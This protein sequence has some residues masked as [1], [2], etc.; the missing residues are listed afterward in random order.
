MQTP[1]P[2]NVAAADTQ[3]NS[4]TH[5]TTGAKKLEHFLSLILERRAN[6]GL[7]IRHSHTSK[8]HLEVDE[9]LCGEARVCIQ[10]QFAPCNRHPAQKQNLHTTPELNN[11]SAM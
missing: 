11:N 9:Q 10:R 8:Q 6:T 1:L 7:G 4:R 2:E 3:E 5:A